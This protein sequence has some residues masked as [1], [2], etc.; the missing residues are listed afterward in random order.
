MYLY[1]NTF[2]GKISSISQVNLILKMLIIT[3]YNYLGSVFYKYKIQ[4]IASVVL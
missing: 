4:A 1:Q 2:C 3:T